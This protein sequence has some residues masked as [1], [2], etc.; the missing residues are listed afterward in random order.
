MKGYPFA[1]NKATAIVVPLTG[2]VKSTAAATI[3]W[4]MRQVSKMESFVPGVK[5]ANIAIG[6]ENEESFD[7]DKR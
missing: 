1:A 6:N 2:N 5:R 7:I 3:C 4:G